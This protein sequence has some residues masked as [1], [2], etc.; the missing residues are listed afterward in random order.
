[1]TKQNDLRH[2][3]VKIK[4]TILNTKKIVSFSRSLQTSGLKGFNSIKLIF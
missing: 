4:P 2:Q 3:A 1:M